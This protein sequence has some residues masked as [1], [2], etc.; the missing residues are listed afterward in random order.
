MDF[1]E[2]VEAEARGCTPATIE[3]PSGGGGDR[4]TATAEA[5]GV[6]NNSSSVGDGAESPKKEK[7]K[8][9]VCIIM[10]MAVSSLSYRLCI[11]R[12]Y[13]CLGGYPCSLAFRFLRPGGGARARSPSEYSERD[14]QQIELYVQSNPTRQEQGQ[15]IG[16]MLYG[17]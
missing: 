17:M 11:C 2:R 5:S 15:I 13:M 8:P 14:E 12:I 7:K 1:L 3:A 4:A 6:G 10:G 9:V 16:E